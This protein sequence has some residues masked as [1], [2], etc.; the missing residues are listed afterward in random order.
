MGAVALEVKERGVE[1][2]QAVHCNEYLTFVRS[3]T[4]ATHTYVRPAYLRSFTHRETNAPRPPNLGS[5][6]PAGER[7]TQRRRCIHPAAGANRAVIGP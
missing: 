7:G 6:F 2:G 5:A 4:Q 1:S 3:V